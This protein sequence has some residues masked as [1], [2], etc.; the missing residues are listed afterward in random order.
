MCAAQGREII[1]ILLIEDHEDIAQR[2]T[3]G[4]TNC[5]F[6]VEWAASGSDGEFL[7]N[8]QEFDA[9]ILDLGL[10][11]RQGI[12]I[13]KNWRRS[14]VDFP[15]LV[16]TARTSWIEKVDTLNGGA[17]DYI[18][19]PFHIPE[20]AARVRALLR[21]TAGAAAPVL[22]HGSIHLDSASGLVTV[23]GQIVDLTSQELKLLNYFMHRP[24]RIISQSDLLD[25]LYSMD[26]ERGPNAI[27]VYVSRLRRKL[28]RDVIK[29]LRGLGYRMG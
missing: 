16:L 17:D 14:G 21:R 20:V 9:A 7:G 23:D 22:K 1:R 28:G 4:L 19:K 24:N 10:P 3:D 12:E 25:H 26:E 5:G 11:D 8:T 18:T 13:L 6:V 29:T 27:E 2:L 15:V